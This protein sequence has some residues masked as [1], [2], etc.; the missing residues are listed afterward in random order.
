MEDKQSMVIFNFILFKEE[1]SNYYKVM[2]V[3]LEEDLFIMIL[4]GQISFASFK[5]NLDKKLQEFMLLKFHLLHKDLQ[6]IKRILK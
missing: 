1:N 6:N 5:E 2:L 3:P 4:I